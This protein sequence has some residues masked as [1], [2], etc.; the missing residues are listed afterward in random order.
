M[1]GLRLASK[2]DSDLSIST[3][4]AEDFFKVYANIPIEE[5]DNVVVVID[6][7]P[8]S[9][10]LAYQEIKNNTLRSKKILKILKD[11]DII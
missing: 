1:G 6:E 7:E 4:G 3:P 10:N 2:K 8:I 5:R 9:W 11:I